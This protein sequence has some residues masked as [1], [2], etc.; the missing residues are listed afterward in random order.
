[1][2]LLEVIALLAARIKCGIASGV[3]SLYMQI[4]IFGRCA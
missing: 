3:P 2:R 4:T 1:M